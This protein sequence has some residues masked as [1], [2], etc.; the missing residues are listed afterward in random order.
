LAILGWAFTPTLQKPE[1]FRASRYRSAG[2]SKRAK[3]AAVVVYCKPLA[4]PDM[5]SSG[6]PA[7]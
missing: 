4:T 1:G 6:F 5:K 2:F 7:G 3:G